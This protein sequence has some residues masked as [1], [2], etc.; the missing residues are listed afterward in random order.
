MNQR[1]S[2]ILLILCA[3]ALPG[4]GQNSPVKTAISEIKKLAYEVPEVSDI[5]SNEG[6]GLTLVSSREVGSDIF[7]IDAQNSKPRMLIGGGARPAWSPDGSQLAYCTWKGVGFGQIE[8]ANADG[9]GG[10]EIT[11][12]KGGACF[13]DW[14]PDG[15]KIAFTALSIGDSEKNLIGAPLNHMEIFVVDK[16]GGDAVPIAP[17][18]AARWSPGGNMLIFLRG[19]EKKGPDGSV[20]IATADGKQSKI[21][22]A[23]DR[24]VAS[25]GWLPD[26]KGIAVS[27][28][29]DLR[30]SI[31]R[32][33]L[34][35]SQP[36]G[37]QSHR[38]AGDDRANWSEPSVSPDGKHVIAVRDCASAPWESNL[39]CRVSSILLLDI[40][41]NRDVIL[42]SGANY[43]V[44][45]ER[46]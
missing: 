27:Y 9:T 40:D 25:A 43:S 36:Q 22:F 14:S 38:I 4:S 21:L 29:H 26:G 45:W 37:N 17:G 11:N 46:K 8:V 41:T 35:G 10:R 33:Y 18:F 6:A 3:G 20:W 31:F 30:Y 24:R 7:I 16:N 5:S 23:S 1:L 44:V 13:P 19:P 39:G 34:D 28:M 15:A 12:M 32:M 42:A 2:A